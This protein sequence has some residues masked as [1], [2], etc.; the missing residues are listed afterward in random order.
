MTPVT[1]YAVEASGIEKHYGGV[2]ALKG[3][4]VR[5]PDGSIFGLIGPNG[6]GKSTMFDIMCG[7]TKPTSGKVSVL[8]MDVVALPAHAVARSGVG[9]SFQ[10]TAMFGEATVYENLLYASYGGMRHNVVQRILRSSAWR[11]DM[12]SFAGK[13]EEVL[14]MC[15]LSDLRDQTA[16][17]LAYGIQRRLAVAIMLMNEPKIIFLDEPVAGM[18]EAETAE[19][20]RLMRA[21]AKGRTI[22]IVE[23]DM[24]AIG[25]LCDE[26]M[27]MVDGKQLVT[28]VPSRV[29]QHPEVIAA[30]LGVD[31]VDND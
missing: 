28:D 20:I 31:D 17:V 1:R 16:S 8:G 19:F 14:S 25:A 13:A 9:R 3:V 27:V 24:A 6:A 11:S 4:D 2:K 18:N 21:T 7:I 23:H 10:R 30:Y 5:I 12:E 15:D 26:V 29:L 22:V